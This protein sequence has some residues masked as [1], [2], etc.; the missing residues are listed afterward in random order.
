V[1]WDPL[2]SGLGSKSGAPDHIEMPV[3][4]AGAKY[5]VNPRGLPPIPRILHDGSAQTFISISGQPW[6]GANLPEETVKIPFINDATHIFL[7]SLE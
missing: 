3:R 5:Y 4:A 7:Q 2:D 6:N 1:L